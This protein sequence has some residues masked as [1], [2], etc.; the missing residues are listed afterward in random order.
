MAPAY[1]NIN[2]I[3]RYRTGITNVL[4]QGPN[5]SYGDFN[6]S[7]PCSL[8]LYTG[9]TDVGTPFQFNIP[10]SN[11]PTP[12]GV[13]GPYY[14]NGS[15]WLD[16]SQTTG[17]TSFSPF[18]GY[19]YKNGNGFPVYLD[20]TPSMAKKKSGNAST[21]K[22]PNG[23][24]AL[25]A[26]AN[27]EG[28]DHNYFG[29]SSDASP[30][31]DRY[32]YPEPPSG[33][34]GTSGYFR[35]AND[36]FCTDIRPEL[37]DGQTW[38]FAVDC[39]GQTNMTI[40][41]S[42]EFPAGIE[43]YLADLS[44]QVS[45][46]IRDN[47]SY[48]FIPEPGEKTREFKIIAGQADYAKAVLGSSFALPAVT[49]LMRNRPNPLSNNTVIGYQLSST[50]PAKLAVYNVAGQLV[51][52]LVNRPQMAGR[53]TIAWNGKDESGRQAATG[54]YFYRLTANGTSAARTMNLIK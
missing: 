48:S 50:G 36:K 2:N 14:Y 25:V 23:W 54:V 39:N 6:Q 49:V 34:T 32:D 10:W 37:G 27:G 22:Q 30:Q 17:G 19:A 43:C 11:V 1:K 33:L 31:C 3:L 7:K 18:K 13:A 4:F 8:I 40:T 38:D 15:T 47:G 16:P 24:Q 51:K 53:Y 21:P 41:L 52:T 28:S 44:R 9:W 46:N 12:A 42:Q 5:K 45:V 20:I 26:V 35:L 29:L